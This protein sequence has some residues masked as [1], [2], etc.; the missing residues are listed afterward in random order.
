MRRWVVDARYVQS[1]V[2]SMV[3]APGRQRGSKG[4]DFGART[5]ND[6]WQE[7][8]ANVKAGRLPEATWM[9]SHQTLGEVVS[10]SLTIED[11]LGNAVADALAGTAAELAQ[12]PNIVLIEAEKQLSLSFFVCMRIAIIEGAVSKFKEET[13]LDYILKGK[14]QQLSVARATS[15][16]TWNLED[17]GHVVTGHGLKF[18]R[19]AVC[20]NIRPLGDL[21]WWTRN[22]CSGFGQFEEK[23]AEGPEEVE[24]E[25]FVGRL[26]EF[27]VHKRKRKEVDEGTLRRNNRRRKDATAKLFA[28]KAKEVPP[29]SWLGGEASGPQPV[30]AAKLH[31][32][33]VLFHAGGGVF[34]S[35]CGAANGRA[36][37]G[38]LQSVCSG[39][40]VAGS[41]W[42]LEG[43]LRGRCAAW[44]A[45]PDG[46]SKQVRVS[47]AR[48]VLDVSSLIH[49]LN[50]AVAK[51][52]GVGVN[53][54]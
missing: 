32:T 19:C 29:A 8:E 45:W 23:V 40:V 48:V 38:K 41:A 27:L 49:E 21:A 52:R 4:G 6:L 28:D 44:A 16:A 18:L 9:K 2:A 24:K 33:H 1:G 43:L 34:C 26:P 17:T 39:N 37:K 36:R 46:R 11:Y 3:Q 15:E 42:R 22:S 7:I 53:R 13:E 30:W 25:H 35:R 31:S 54:D 12:V 14:V 50:L 47:T 5:N 20:S 51:E 10:G